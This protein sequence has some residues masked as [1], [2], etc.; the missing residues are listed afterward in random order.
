MAQITQAGALNT[1]AL[2]VPDL[3]VQIASPQSLALNGVATDRIGIVGTASWGPVNQ[4]V[5]LGSVADYNA[6]F[7]SILPRQYDLGTPLRL[8]AAAGCLLICRGPGNGRYRCRGYLRAS[9]HQWHLSD[10]ANG[11]LLRQQG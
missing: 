8:C 2:I 5:V 4:P 1:A 9:L 7:G 10:A 11:G 6:A 3:Y